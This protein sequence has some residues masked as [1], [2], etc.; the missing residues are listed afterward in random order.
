MSKKINQNLSFL[1]K[2]KKLSISSDNIRC[3]LTTKAFKSELF[4][5]IQLATKRIYLA[6]LYLEADEAGE[7]VLNALYDAKLRHPE[8]DIAICID[9]HRAQRGLIGSVKGGD[10]NTTWYQKIAELRGHG[11]KIFGLPV[12][13]KELFGVQHL[14]GFV[15]DDVVFYSGA[16]INNIYLHQQDKYRFDR[17]WLINDSALADSMVGYLQQVIVSS[18]AVVQLNTAVVPNFNELKKHHKSLSRDLKRCGYIFKGPDSDGLGIRPLTGI[19]ANKN[20]L[21]KVIRSIFHCTE[22]ELI[23][24]TPYFNLPTVLA[25]DISSL[26][27]RNVQITIVVGDK[28][29]NDF[30][31]PEDKPFKTISALPY[32]Y[33]INLRNFAKKHHQSILKG[34]L[35]IHL[36]KHEGNSFHLK[37]VYSDKRYALLTGHNLNPRAWRLDLENALL[38]EDPK[39]ELSE[40][41]LAELDN[42]LVHTRLINDYKEIDEIKT[43]PSKVYQLI[44]RLKRV[45]ADKIIKGIV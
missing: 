17:Y 15:F 16:S 7:E 6:A 8:M 11:V 33:E 37:G 45:K 24:F 3:L 28:T 36:W 21:N 42:I 14:K 34:N 32:L 39:Q 30:Y 18:D 20:I 22:K 19:G 38:I 31:I 23:L 43:Y 10:T 13:R 40:L 44:T 5:Q 2:M 1:Q 4:N 29:A 9:F 27:K 26:L 25:R 12:K 35:K 41:M